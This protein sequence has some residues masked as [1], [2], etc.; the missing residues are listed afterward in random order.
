MEL[1][2]WSYR[3]KLGLQAQA[4]LEE[5]AVVFVV[6]F[7]AAVVVAEAWLRVLWFR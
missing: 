5:A 3:E 7:V 2:T 1:P 6:A 4:Q